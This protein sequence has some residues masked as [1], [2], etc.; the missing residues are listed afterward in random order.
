MRSPRLQVT[1]PLTIL[2]TAFPIWWILGLAS[3]TWVIVAAPLA[4]A[5]LWRGWTRAPVAFFLWLAFI[6]WVFLSGLQITAG[7]TTL[8]FIYR[9]VLYAMAGL[10]FLYV[11]NMPRSGPLDGKILRILTI[12]W[13]V[14]VVGGYAGI[15]LHS[16]TFVPPF[17][18]LLP[19]GLRNKPFVQELVEPVFAQVQTFLGYPVP[20]PAAPFT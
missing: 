6:T 11:Y 8:T 18:H 9:L 20:R 2:F 16:Y 19:H 13:M 5:L 10:L 1:W 15:L 17:D 14:V 3:L 4:I 12:F 7:T